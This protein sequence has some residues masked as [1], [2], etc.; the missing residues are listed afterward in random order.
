MGET[1]G[2]IAIVAIEKWTMYLSDLI[3][4]KEITENDRINRTNGT[5]GS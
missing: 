2:T 4:T 1:Q 5:N 3:G